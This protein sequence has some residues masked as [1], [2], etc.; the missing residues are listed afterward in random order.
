MI[1]QL[2]CDL[3]SIAGIVGIVL[4]ILYIMAVF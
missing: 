2:A 1:K 3:L 4:S